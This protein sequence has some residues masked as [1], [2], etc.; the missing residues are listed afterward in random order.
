[1]SGLTVLE[2]ESV[3]EVVVVVEV[4]GNGRRRGLLE[5]LDR[6]RSY[7]YDKQPACVWKIVDRLPTRSEFISQAAA[8]TEAS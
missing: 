7:V 4:K 1:M 3:L 2:Q 8:T 5:K 6:A